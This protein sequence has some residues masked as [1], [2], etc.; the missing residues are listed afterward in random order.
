MSSSTPSLE[1]LFPKSMSWPRLIVKL[2]IESILAYNFYNYN[3]DD[4]KPD[5]E[6]WATDK[7]QPNGIGVGENMTEQ[8]SSVITVG[9]YLSLIAACCSCVEV[10]NKKVNNK[11]LTQI[12]G[13]IDTI[14]AACA[15]AWVIWASMIRLGRNGK[16]CSGGTTNV[17]EPTYP[18]AYDQGSFLIVMLVLSYVVPPTLL[19]ATNCGCL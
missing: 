14:V 6:C 3:S 7:R 11:Q 19:V 4:K 10:I 9:F 16:I 18:Y 5:W 2:G 15:L 8:F 12:T 13:L 17:S 1:Q